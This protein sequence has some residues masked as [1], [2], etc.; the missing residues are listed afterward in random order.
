MAGLGLWHSL[1]ATLTVEGAVFIIGL[2]L[3]L[4]TTRATDRVGRFALWGLAAFLVAVYMGNLFGTPP[5]NV[6]VIAWTGQAQ[7]IL[8]VWAYWVDRHRTVVS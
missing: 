3:Y 6:A 1:P 7:W 8:V 5:P 4:R 2:A